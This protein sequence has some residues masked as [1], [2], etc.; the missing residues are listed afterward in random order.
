[1]IYTLHHIYIY[2]HIT[3]AYIFLYTEPKYFGEGGG[4]VSSVKNK[5]RVSRRRKIENA[6]YYKKRAL[7]WV[8]QEIIGRL[9]FDSYFFFYFP[10]TYLSSKRGT[11]Q[12]ADMSDDPRVAGSASLRVV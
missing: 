2:L 11:C 4:V 6:T 8:Q 5:T 3:C 7:I 1:L 9:N 12:Y 10:Y